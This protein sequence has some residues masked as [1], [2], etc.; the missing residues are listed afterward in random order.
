MTYPVFWEQFCYCLKFPMI[1]Y[2][3]H[4]TVENTIN[5]VVSFATAFVLK[6]E[7]QEEE[8]EE[9]SI[10]NDQEGMHPFLFKLFQFLLEVNFV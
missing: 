6:S 4:P 7:D 3:R 2:E 10:L 9:D 5:F 1:V 8:E